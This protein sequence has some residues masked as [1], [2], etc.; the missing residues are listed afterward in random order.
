[1]KVFYISLCLSSF[2]LYSQNILICDS[3]TKKPI[4]FAN[5]KSE[6][7]GFYAD[8]NGIAVL[9]PDSQV[10]TISHISYHPK[11]IE[12]NKILDTI[13]LLER[14]IT[15]EEIIVKNDR[16][17]T[18]KFGFKK[19]DNRIASIPLTPKHEII[20]E[21][22]PTFKFKELKICTIEI[23]LNKIKHYNVTDKKIKNKA[24]VF[25]INIYAKINEKLELIY[26]SK[27][28]EFIMSKKEKINFDLLKENLIIRENKFF[29]SLEMIGNIDPSGN[30][31]GDDEY[32]RPI[33]T[34][35]TDEN[36]ESKTF[37]KSSFNN[38]IADLHELNEFNKPLS[39]SFKNYKERNLN[40]SI[41]IV[42]E[43]NKSN[44]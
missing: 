15:L 32:I 5:I 31:V 38:N 9:P 23:P 12:S 4:Q 35:E 26:Q 29:V 27:F 24:S 3:L 36:Y 20:M 13:F 44:L 8:L 28:R 41:G 10:Y 11:K 2:S 42:V 25:R 14:T 6:E 30:L 18:F 40:L 7:E 17:E 16:I 34:S 33:I 21:I 1:M 22:K 19:R 39:E 37:L 43:I